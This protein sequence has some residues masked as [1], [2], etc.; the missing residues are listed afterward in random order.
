[1][2]KRLQI[3]ITNMSHN[4][5][6][7]NE[8]VTYAE[9]F[10]L[11]KPTITASSCATH[12]NTLY[13]LF[14]GRT[15]K[16]G[17]GNT[18]RSVTSESEI[19]N[20]ISNHLNGTTRLGFYNLLP[21]GTSPWA[22][23]EFENHGKST[24]L[25]EPD[26]ISRQCVEDLASAGIPSYRELSKNPNGKCYHVWIFFEKPLSAKKVHTV[27]K[28]YVNEVMDVTTE[29][30][31][32][33]YDPQN[34]MGHFV[35]LPLFGGK[36]NLG[37]GINEGK[38]VFVDLDE[39]PIPDQH[40][41]IAQIKRA[42]EA[43]LDQLVSQYK[44]THEK[45]STRTVALLDG[46]EK[47]RQCS[48]MKHCE[49]NASAL[50]EPLWYAWITNAARFKG[51][52][53]YIHTYS[54][55]YPG[56]DRI[57]TDKKITHAL[58]DSGAMTH[59]KIKELGFEC[60][61]PE[62]IRS[63]LER[64]E[65]IDLAAEVDRVKLIKDP[66]VRIVE[67][68]KLI[69]YWHKLDSVSQD[70]YRS[71]LKKELGVGNSV[72]KAE[73]NM[74]F[75]SIDFSEDLRS[76][77]TK[78]KIAKKSYEESGEIVYNWL[79]QRGVKFYKDKDHAHY[80]FTDRK[81]MLINKQDREFESFLYGVTGVTTATKDGEVYVKVLQ[82]LTE[83]DGTKISYNTWLHTDEENHEIY[84]NLN[85]DQQEL[86]QITPDG[87]TLMENG[88]NQKQILLH[89]SSKIQ[90][91]SYTP[92]TEV[93]YTEGLRKLKSL[94]VDN[95]ACQESDRIFS[96]A[97]SIAGFFVDYVRTTPSLRFEG[98]SEGGKSTGMELVSFP[99]YGSDQK[100]TSTTASNY[101]DA[102]LNPIVL[103][104]NIEASEMSE[105]LKN[106]IITVVTGINK[107]KRKLGT[108]RE[109][110][111]EKSKCLI[112]STGIENWSI[113]E[114]INRSYFVEFDKDKYGNGFY[115]GVFV[116]IKKAR[117]EIMSAEFQLVSKVL[118]KIQ[119]GTWRD[120]EVQLGKL[121]PGHSKSRANAF[122]ALMILVTEE[123]LTA[124]DS[125]QKAWD[126][127]DVWIDTQ[128]GISKNTS[129]DSNP[130][131]QY[132]NI[133]RKEVMRYREQQKSY[134]NNVVW[135]FDV[136]IVEIN[137]QENKFTVTGFA[138][139]LHS[140]FSKLCQLRSLPYVFKSA[141]Q[142]SSRIKNS[143]KSLCE[144]GW[145]VTDDGIEH[146]E[147]KSYFVRYGS[148][149]TADTTTSLPQGLP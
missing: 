61:C 95:L 133:L 120:Y 139:D 68:E 55:K 111:V 54:E 141:R 90:P 39:E 74:D 69:K 57:E 146:R 94:V 110:V 145:F 107:E 51:G 92:L 131:M 22:V 20:L 41:F 85:N 30:F 58:E 50:T 109:L 15:D 78:C 65:Y 34:S 126:L 28:S 118:K 80:L 104:D 45:Q 81:L 37:E 43:D 129:V 16:V 143:Q 135:P 7:Q 71:I 82:A 140:T 59:A 93:E 127:V 138:K 64:A 103:L 8:S 147:G 79:L 84:F 76:I 67:I 119:D 40:D 144:A 132:L 86:V 136:D 10:H 11:E 21:D 26:K 31:P 38:T 102:A 2:K 29:V 17:I 47:A 27:L 115:D 18:S 75:D 14:K 105:A 96:T 35:R 49:Q 108:D 128:N 121:Y 122:L 46:L 32:K 114:V 99:M 123:L 106:F 19:T 91:I 137:A 98:D 72:F 63:P 77:L 36:D 6:Q 25:Q 117:N 42:K 62:N 48:F 73:R 1:M 148:S 112:C 83:R 125:N 66:N 12:V 113:P 44:L 52:R 4:I 97:W 23:I 149:G 100:K 88:N 5:E 142:L 89:S 53:K 60:D 70:M 130:I 24:D 101:T 3:Q 134:T 9:T 116:E 33:G 124:W 13:D 56:Y 87:V